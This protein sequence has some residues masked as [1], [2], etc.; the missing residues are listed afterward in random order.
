MFSAAKTF[1]A[2]ALVVGAQ[3]A[4]PAAANETTSK[5]YPA[6]PVKLVL[7]FPPGGSADYIARVMAERLERRTGQP[8]IV[9]NRAGA[10][11]N[12]AALYVAKSASDGYTLF[13]GTT[14]AMT[15]NT[16]LYPELN[17]NPEK[18]FTAI[19]LIGYSPAV[20]VA[21]T[22]S[23]VTTLTQMIDLVKKNP[24]KYTFATNGVGTSH[25]LGAE[26]FK[27]AGQLNMQHVPYK[28]TPAAMQDIVG[29]RIPFGVVDM[30]A[31]LPQ[32]A[33]GR[34]KALAT[35]GAVR[36]SALPNVPTIA[37]TGF[38]GFDA[39]GWVALFGPQGLDP[40]IVRFLNKEV[41]L[42]L[43]DPD[44]KQKGSQQGF[45]VAGSTAEKFKLFLP[46]EI[47]KWR[48]VITT[49]NVKLE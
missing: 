5:G 24:G 22:E 36:A 18:D 16:S 26:M 48:K 15:I 14:G 31:A 27:Q 43:N 12:I 10:A 17:F 42:V 1:I 6:K 46:A 3:L 37:E 13:V 9:E 23:N 8:F 28:G 49:G 21:S 11:G 45:D 19:S 2:M 33:A 4:V 29:G 44:V 38:P 39:V 20:V 32:I 47:V 34:M 40:E 30:T 7:P 35:T 25:H 41:N